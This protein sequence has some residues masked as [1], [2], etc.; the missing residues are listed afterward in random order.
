MLSENLGDYRNRRVD[1]ICVIMSISHR[2]ISVINIMRT[3]DHKD[4]GLGAMSGNPLGKVADDS[5]ID[6]P[7]PIDKNDIPRQFRRGKLYL[8]KVISGFEGG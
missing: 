3:G 8:E 5:S 6:L 2:N 7:K 4:E 1:W